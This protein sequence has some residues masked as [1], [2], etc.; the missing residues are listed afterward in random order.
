MCSIRL[1]G[2]VT[3][4]LC[5]HIAHGPCIAGG[6]AS[7]TGEVAYIPYVGYIVPVIYGALDGSWWPCVITPS[8]VY[9]AGRPA[10]LPSKRH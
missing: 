1:L 5:L 8:M 7:M 2:T 6:I 3:V 10:I 9:I 4:V